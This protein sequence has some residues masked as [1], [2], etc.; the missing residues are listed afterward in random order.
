VVDNLQHIGGSRAAEQ[1]ESISFNP[2]L[3]AWG[4]AGALCIW[5]LSSMSGTPWLAA[6]AAAVAIY[7]V[8]AGVPAWRWVS[9]SRCLQVIRFWPH[10]TTFLCASAAGV[11]LADAPY[12]PLAS[13]GSL[14]LIILLAALGVLSLLLVARGL[15]AL[16][17]ALRALASSGGDSFRFYAALVVLSARRFTDADDQVE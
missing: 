11:L 10:A 5:G 12:R 15:R 8:Y 2:S 3:L 7:T 6:V 14:V 9:V 16:F 13:L 1:P 17:D 4:A